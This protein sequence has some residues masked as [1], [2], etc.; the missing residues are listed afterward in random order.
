MSPVSPKEIT[1]RCYCGSTTFRGAAS[2]QTIAYC[3]CD[4]CR[5]ATGGPVAAFAAFMDGEIAFEPNEGRQVNVNPGVVRTFCENCGSSLTGRYDYLP[6]QVY[7]S[8]GVIDQASDLAPQMHVHEAQ[9]LS[10]LHIDD[11]V[12]RSYTTARTELNAACDNT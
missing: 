4:D 12:K 10:W 1:G 8:I 3:H 11:D 2:P 7:I 5:R 6:N 9:R